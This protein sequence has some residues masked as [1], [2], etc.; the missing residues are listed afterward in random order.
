MS[1]GESLY[2]PRQSREIMDLRGRTHEEDVDESDGEEE[3]A[4]DEG[5]S[6][7][8]VREHNT[9]DK[10]LDGTEHSDAKVSTERRECVRPESLGEGGGRRHLGDDAEEEEDACRRGYGRGDNQRGY[11]RGD[12]RDSLQRIRL[13]VEKRAP[14]TWRGMS[15][16]PTYPQ[17]WSEEVELSPLVTDVVV[18]AD[19]VYV[20]PTAEDAVGAAARACV[21]DAAY[22]ADDKSSRPTMTP[23]EAR[24]LDTIV[25]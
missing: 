14:P 23:F 6:S 10:E 11:S 7:R 16:L 15:V 24:V 13:R 2:R 5:E 4:S 18:V 22:T 21:A 20:D 1:K 17:I 3:P 12:G 19:V 8:G 9:T 25:V